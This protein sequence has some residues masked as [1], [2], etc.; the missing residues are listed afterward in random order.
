MRPKKKKE[1]KESIF[2]LSKHYPLMLRFI[3]QSTKQQSA[4]MKKCTI[5]V[6]F[7]ANGH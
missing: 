6:S 2:K 3:I 4:R 5:G 1:K 7:H